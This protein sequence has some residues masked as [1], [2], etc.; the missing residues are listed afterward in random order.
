MMIMQRDGFILYDSDPDQIG[1]NTFSDPLYQSF[2]QLLSLC[3][4]VTDNRYG[5]GSY[6]FWDETRSRVVNKTA[7]WNTV[8]LH[9]TEWRLL[10][11]PKAEVTP[12]SLGIVVEQ[13]QPDQ[14][15]PTA[16]NISTL[17]QPSE[18]AGQDTAYQVSLID[19]LLTGLYDG[20]VPLGELKKHGDLGIGTFDKLD[21]EMLVLDGTVYKMRYNGQAITMPDSE[22]TPFAVVTFFN[23]DQKTSLADIGSYNLLQEKLQGL[24]I[25]PNLFYAIRIDGEFDYVKARSVPPQ[26]KPYPPLSRVTEKQSTFEYTKVKGT[27]AGFWCPKYIDGINVP[28][29]HLHFITGDR[30]SGGHLL[31][32]RLTRGTALVDL[33]PEL[34]LNLPT[35]SDF[36]GID[37]T[38]ARG[39][40]LQKVEK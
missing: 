17:H 35:T 20:T 2:P 16:V 14:V 3:K 19:A 26:E 13:S 24:I 22:T 10:L 28:G 18:P 37:L 36:A 40:E 8:E 9:G 33:T 39:E 27:I 15:K 4:K 29:F 25:N 11:I 31:E 6:S 12:N 30:T 7:F 23:T 32:C 5:T 1:R 21:G 34:H 38:S